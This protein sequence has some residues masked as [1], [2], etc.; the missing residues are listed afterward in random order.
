MFP[1]PEEAAAA[2]VT[3]AGAQDSNA[4]RVIFGPA[5]SELE[6][7]DPVEAAEEHDAFA[8][9]LKEGTRIVHESDSRCILE[10]SDKD[11]PF[12]IPI[13]KKDGQWVF[14]TAA[15]KE[16]I[17][18]RRIGKDELATLQAA[19]AYVEAQREYASHDEDGDQILEYA[20]RLVSSPGTHDGLYWPTEP[21][22]EPSPLG[23][24][25]A[26]AQG[27][28]KGAGAAVE[29]TPGGPFHGYY[30]KILTRQGSHA[31]GG[32]Y[33]YVING[34]M[35]AGFAM[36]A[37][38]ARYGDSGI[39]TF[40]VNQQGRV[41]QKDLGAKTSKLVEEMKAY[42]PDSTWRVSRE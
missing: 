8:K 22:G 11:W 33:D 1:T 42:D 29:D 2:L 17:L 5:G 3:A 12:P 27:V 32:K 37:W 26:F 21:D 4:L 39:M 16:E 13:V 14:D 36:V 15:G 9:A 10:V 7:P 35:I 28:G 24:L 41:Y 34:K 40:M 6:N 25:V 20:Q 23:P 19:R 31:L 18:N 38:P 30:F